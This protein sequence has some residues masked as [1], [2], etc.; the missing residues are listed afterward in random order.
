MN[1]FSTTDSR[2]NGRFAIRH[3]DQNQSLFY[4][5]DNEE[6]DQ[7]LAEHADDFER[8]FDFILTPHLDRRVRHLNVHHRSYSA[9][10]MQRGGAAPIDLNRTSRTNLPQQ[11]EQAIHRAINEQVLQD[12]EVRPNDFLLI[13]INSNRLRHA[14]HSARLR[15]REW[16]QNTV[17]AREVLEQISR[18]LNSNEQF[19]MDNTFSL[20][21]SHI[22][23]PGRGSGAPR[24]KLGTAPIEKILQNKKSVSYIN[25]TDELC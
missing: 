18:M 13:N 25:N 8:G 9:R 1:R 12:P 6:D 24:K 7:L 14:Y 21:I 17:R 3:F 11:M 23:D 22:Q 16:Q 10:L 4:F 15:V 20:H 2:R 5:D 19:K